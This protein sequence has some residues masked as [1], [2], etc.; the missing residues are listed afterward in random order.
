M[1]NIIYQ[2]NEQP[3]D[4]SCYTHEVAFYIFADEPF[5]DTQLL[6]RYDLYKVAGMEPPAAEE[7]SFINVL[8]NGAAI[9][10]RPAEKL[11]LISL[12]TK[13]HSEAMEIANCFIIKKFIFNRK[14][15]Y[16]NYSK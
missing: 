15:S 10:M 11:P 3:D 13:S 14:N 6:L 2:N 1:L 8:L 16:R 5:N 4:P 7:K 9:F 12:H